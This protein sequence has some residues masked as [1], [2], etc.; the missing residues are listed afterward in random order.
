MTTTPVLLLLSR[1]SSVQALQQLAP[2]IVIIVVPLFV[3]SGRNYLR[4]I[5]PFVSRMLAVAS[6]A[7]PWNWSSFYEH[8]STPSDPRKILP[9]RTRAEQL[10]ARTDGC[11][12]VE[13]SRS[14]YPGL[15]NISGTYCFMNST[16]QALASLSYL[17]P[18]IDAIHTKAEAVDIATPV[19]DA[20]RDLLHGLNTPSSHYRTIRPVEMIAA[21]SQPEPGKRI[22]LFSSREHQDAQELFQLVSEY[23]KKEATAV[24]REGARDLGFAAISS[25]SSAETAAAS[26]DVSKGVFDGLTANR[27][28]CCECGY[29]E[30]VMHFPFDNWQLTVPRIASCRLEDCL[31]DYIRLEV[32]TDCI[33]RKCSMRATLYKLEQDAE[34]LA[35]AASKSTVS[36][37]K[38]K[39]VREVKRFAT[40]L[41]AALDE[42]RIEDDIKGVKMEKVFSRASTKQ[43][44]V[45]R[46]PPVLALHLN[47]SVHFG[48]YASKNTA[49]V[50]FPEVLDLTPYTTSGML[51]TSP[52]IPISSHM[53][54]TTATSAAAAASLAIPSSLSSSKTKTPPPRVLYRLAAVVCHYGQHSFGHYVCFRRKP[55]GAGRVVPPRL[56]EGPSAAPP[57]GRGWLRVSDDAVREVGIET[58]LLEGAGAFMLYYERVVGEDA[59]GRSWTGAGLHAWEAGAGAEGQEKKA[60]QIQEGPAIHEPPGREKVVVAA[61][62]P[63]TAVIKARV[64]RSVSLGP[65]EV[66]GGSSVKRE[67][68]AEVVDPESS[69]EV[70]EPDVPAAV[71]PAVELPLA[72]P[73][74]ALSPIPEPPVVDEPPI[75]LPRTVDL[76]A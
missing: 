64:V 17:Q 36:Q 29:T 13:E 41:K 19:V 63:P 20:L 55:R 53:P 62:S 3:L 14:F 39:R 75:S 33:C 9:I 67:A 34:R 12:D 28:S 46:P 71:A 65:D 47:R 69:F 11:P 49:R 25:L 56:D 68:H 15:V 74:K 31:M 59:S 45:A 6:S 61:V 76:R 24:D 26:C 50:H 72:A 44:M 42:G 51:S 58:V 5:P 35:A 57:A 37:S 52:S 16:M 8:R 32:L 40:R 23:V 70:D 73:V 60:Q 2:L 4:S 43:A 48:A 66:L 1:L 10:A 7:L 30:A 22:P 21:L 27:R 18:H 38:K 54:P